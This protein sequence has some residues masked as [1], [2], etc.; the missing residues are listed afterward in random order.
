M[1]P[2]IK[3]TVLLAD[4]GG[5]H[6]RFAVWRGNSY[7]VPPA[8]TLAEAHDCLPTAIET[9]LSRSF[10][11][12]VRLDGVSVC[13]AGPVQS[14]GIKLTNSDW[15]I[16]TNELIDVTKVIDPV[17]VNDF[18]AMAMGV[19]FIGDE[20]RIQ[21]GGTR[22]VPRSAMAVLGPGTGLGVSGLV[23]GGD[24]N[25]W[26]ISGEGGHVDLPA[27]TPRE[28]E[29]VRVMMDMEADGHVSAEDV[30]SGP[31]LEKLYRA[32]ARIEGKDV[33]PDLIPAHVSHMARD[34]SCVMAS[35]AIDLFT[36]WLGSVSGNAALTLGAQG[37]VYLTGGIL[38]KWE[39]I[40]DSDLLRRHFEAKGDFRGYLE[41]IPIYQIM[42]GRPAMLGLVDLWRQLRAPAR[43]TAED[44]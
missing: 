12:P 31:G 14:W 39:G 19:R 29:I 17:I 44:V 18:T 42:G 16:D 41:P 28:I 21:I 34:R 13:G 6:A 26:P 9:F 33:K 1:L 2:H 4:I 23:P 37:G 24:G 20:H 35:E 38:P 11:G 5:T 40:F 32:I 8:Q 25:Y 22:P 43:K 15:C 36:A 7:L 27:I 30:L 10:E 3:Q